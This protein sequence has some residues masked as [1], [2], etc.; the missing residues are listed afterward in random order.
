MAGEDRVVLL[1]SGFM[2]NPNNMH[3]KPIKS[4][5]END[6]NTVV[7]TDHPLNSEKMTRKKIFPLG[8]E[9]YKYIENELSEY[10]D[11]GA[12]L[13][14]KAGPVGRYPDN[15]DWRIAM[16]APHNGT[17]AAEAISPYKGV[18]CLRKGSD[19]LERLNERGP[20]PDVEMLNIQ[21]PGD[22]LADLEASRPPGKEYEEEWENFVADYNRL[23]EIR[24]NM[25]SFS[26]EAIQMNPLGAYD[27]AW[28]AIGSSSPH[29]G[30][31]PHPETLEKVADF[32]G[33]EDPE[34]DYITPSDSFA[35]GLNLLNTAIGSFTPSY[36]DS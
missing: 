27:S 11:I 36:G 29:I 14:S 23:E 6:P 8:K 2:D 28:K 25:V 24:N 33:I 1:V 19:C 5:L 13:H 10:S 20:D 15:L 30:G 7:D 4:M 3:W 34:I 18:D 9:L 16:S 31:V 17:E 32:I 35:T 21:V 22:I 12:V 26:R